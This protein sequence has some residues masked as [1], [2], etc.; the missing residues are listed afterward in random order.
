M[1][2]WIN[3][4]KILASCLSVHLS[5]WNDSAS[6]GRI[7]IKFE[8]WEFFRKF[9][10]NLNFFP[11][12]FHEIWNFSVFWKFH[13]IWAF[14]ENIHEIWN[15][16]VFFENCQIWNYS[17]FFENF[18]EIWAFFFFRKSIENIQVS[19]NQYRYC[20]WRPTY[21]YNIWLNFYYSEKYFRQ[22]S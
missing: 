7:F 4:K 16:R 13:E 15:L 2:G 8:I 5:A 11:E 17:V 20:T 9:S 19:L 18:H 6:T 12:N 14:F 10:W 22:K 3:I 21:I 1:H